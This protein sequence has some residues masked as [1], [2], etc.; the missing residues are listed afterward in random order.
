MIFVGFGFL[1]TFLKRYSNSAIALNFFTSCL[2]RPNVRP[3]VQLSH[4]LGLLVTH[5]VWQALA[6]AI[7]KMCNCTVD[8]LPLQVMLEFIVVG[9]VIQQMLWGSYS[10]IQLDIPLLIDAAFAAGAA[11]ISF[12]AVLGRTTPTQIAWLLALQVAVQLSPCCT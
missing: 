12:G 11:M 6:D 9:G 3:S 1:M 2:V 8:L 7:L 5:V 4:V 10:R